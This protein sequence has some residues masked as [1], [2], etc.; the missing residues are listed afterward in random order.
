[1]IKPS[2]N[3]LYFIAAA[4]LLAAVAWLAMPEDRPVA[5]ERVMRETALRHQ[6]RN[7]K[8]EQRGELPRL[9]RLAASDPEQAVREAS[10]L[11]ESSQRNDI[12][13]AAAAELVRTDCRAALEIAET[14]PPSPPRNE[15][16]ERAIREWGLTD[17]AGAIARAKSF[18]DE[19]LRERL[20]AA[21]LVEW[22]GT[23]P[24]AAAR[25]AAIELREGRIQD[26]AI[27][28]ISQRWAQI[29]PAEAASWIESFPP[30]DLQDAARNG[31]A[32]LGGKDH[33]LGA[34]DR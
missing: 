32:R 6:V 15:V 33:A 10:A 3:R 27:V 12:L 18:S 1:M 2:S 9:V 25:L 7:E 28:S 31:Q 16:L 21:A 23:D 5:K 30:S 17:P 29:A 22:S 13:L 14:L 11:P 24:V 4:G 19:P 26:D 20:Y 8:P 34:Q